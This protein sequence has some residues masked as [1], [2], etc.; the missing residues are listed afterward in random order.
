MIKNGRM[1]LEK[2]GIN[3][4]IQKTWQVIWITRRVGDQHLPGLLGVGKL[5]NLLEG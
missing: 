3:R 2:D 5:L 4:L 1:S